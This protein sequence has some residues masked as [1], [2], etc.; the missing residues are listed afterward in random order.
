MPFETQ[1]QFPTEWLREIKWDQKHTQAHW[2]M[3]KHIKVSV[4]PTT[5]QDNQSPLSSSGEKQCVRSPTF[6][7]RSQEINV[8]VWILSTVCHGWLVQT[9]TEATSHLSW[10]KLLLK[11]YLR[12][13]PSSSIKAEITHYRTTVQPQA[14][15]N[16]T[17][18]ISLCLRTVPLNPS[19]R[20]QLHTGHPL[21]Q[22]DTWSIRLSGLHPLRAKLCYGSYYGNY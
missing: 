1:P 3:R 8:W 15:P 11:A 9:A 13:S 12:S 17:L 2:G 16:C 5:I 6:T 22:K 19:L 7:E 14:D 20:P 10:C 21:F 4:W 18:H